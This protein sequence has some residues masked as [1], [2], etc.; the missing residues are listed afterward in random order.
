M[1]KRTERTN[2]TKIRD[3]N[4]RT[5]AGIT[6]EHPNSNGYD[7]TETLRTR[8]MKKGWRHPRR[9]IVRFAI[10]RNR[11]TGSER[12]TLRIETELKTETETKWTN[13]ENDP[14]VPRAVY[15]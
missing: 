13:T 6:T 14:Y 12:K 11:S 10:I 8:R 3:A 15:S 9:R 7:S 5:E 4:D 2:K 1:E